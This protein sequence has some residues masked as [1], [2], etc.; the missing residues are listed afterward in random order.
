MK[1]KKYNIL[2][3]NLSLIMII[4]SFIITNNSQ[5]KYIIEEKLF[6]GTIEIIKE[7]NIIN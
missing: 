6:I 5:A 1:L 3:V 2:L 4:S 7:E